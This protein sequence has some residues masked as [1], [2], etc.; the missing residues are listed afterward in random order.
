MLKRS[1]IYGNQQGKGVYFT[2][3]LDTC[4]FY[5]GPGDN[6][7]NMNKIPAIGDIFIFFMIIKYFPYNKI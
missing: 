5:G 7:E 1:E 6:K 4:W 3:C 2:D